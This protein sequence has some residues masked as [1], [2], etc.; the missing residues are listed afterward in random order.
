M[1][2]LAH[3]APAPLARVTGRRRDWARDAALVG[4]VTGYTGPAWLIYGLGLHPHLVACALAGGL[5]GAML[6]A[7]A[8][9]V[10]DLVR[11]RVSLPA[12]AVS[13]PVLGFF[14][15]W[16]A[17]ALA[18]DLV[19]APVGAAARFGAVALAGQIALFWLPYTVATVTRLPRWPVLL[20]ACLV[21]PLLGPAAVWLAMVL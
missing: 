9:D 6:G 1:S 17:A 16:G 3:T 4:L 18:A 8:P 20:I 5:V 15:G 7:V 12:L 11:G 13:L 2:Q 14:L 10:L 19:G 21:S